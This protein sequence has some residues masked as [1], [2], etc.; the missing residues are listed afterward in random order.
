MRILNIM[1]GD[2]VGG[3]EF[4]FVNYAHALHRAGHTVLNCIEPSAKIRYHLSSDLAVTSLR[5]LSQFDPRAI[6]NAHR[7]LETYKP[8][9]LI[10]HGKRADRI[11]PSAQALFGKTVPH[12]EVL[13]RPR[14]HVLRRADMTFTV[15]DDLHDH[16]IYTG[17]DVERVVTLPNFLLNPPLQQ[18]VPRPLHN[19]LNIGFLG[20]LVPEKGVDLLLDAAA[21]LHQRGIPF[22]LRIGG[23]GP[24]RELLQQQ[25]IAAGIDRYITWH[26]WISDAA[27]FLQRLD[28]LCVPSYRE[29]FGLIIIEAFSHATPVIATRVSGPK[30]LIRHGENGMLCDKHPASIA[31]TIALLLADPA[32]MQRMAQ[33]AAIDA[34]RYYASNVVQHIE[35]ALLRTRDRF[36]DEAA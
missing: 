17:G 35:A 13:H 32:R 36:Q 16:F 31:D 12:V 18:A 6:T 26:G 2:G 27:T 15:T 1:L 29:S 14:F 34:T 20:R 19:P 7:M 5:Q 8:D 25:A 4:A 9:I 11:F 3:I 10:A 21:L 24:L 33:A 28:M 30:S 23:D 22:H